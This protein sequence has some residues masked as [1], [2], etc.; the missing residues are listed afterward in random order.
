MATFQATDFFTGAHSL[1]N[2][3]VTTAGSKVSL[4][5]RFVATAGSVVSLLNCFVLDSCA[6]GLRVASLTY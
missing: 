5:K 4:L 1:W 2:C 6:F 3:F